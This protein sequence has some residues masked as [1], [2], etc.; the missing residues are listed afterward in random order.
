MRSIASKADRAPSRRGSSPMT[1]DDLTGCLTAISNQ[2]KTAFKTS[3][4]P[5]M[6][7]TIAQAPSPRSSR[8]SPPSRPPQ[9]HSASNSPGHRRVFASAGPPEITFLIAN[10]RNITIQFPS[11]A[12]PTCPQNQS[13]CAIISSKC[14]VISTISLKVAAHK[15]A[16]RVGSPHIWA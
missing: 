16:L 8:K 9:E 15:S 12:A 1:A 5:E 14:S 7:P 10:L 4:S 6:R 13:Y 11:Y 2:L 3:S